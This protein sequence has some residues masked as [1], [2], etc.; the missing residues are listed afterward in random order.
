MCQEKKQLNSQKLKAK[1]SQEN[2]Q[3]VRKEW[4]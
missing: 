4:P 1:S 2:Q 3:N